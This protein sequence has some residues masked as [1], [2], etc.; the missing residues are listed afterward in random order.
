M[1]KKIAENKRQVRTFLPSWFFGIALIYWG[2]D[3]T[4]V[5]DL[6]GTYTYYGAVPSVLVENL[7]GATLLVAGSLSLIGSLFFSRFMVRLG[8]VLGGLTNL[9]FA[10]GFFIM[11]MTNILGTTE[12]APALNSAFSQATPGMNYGVAGMFYLLMGTVP[13]TDEVAIG[14]TDIEDMMK[15]HGS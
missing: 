14:A 5:R 12:V 8:F 1:R 6:T 13:W 11:A 9:L 10:A 4:F 15:A 3:F 2:V 7:I